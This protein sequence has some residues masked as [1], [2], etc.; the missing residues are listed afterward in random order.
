MSSGFARGALAALLL[1]GLVALRLPA[2]QGYRIG[3]GDTLKVL[4]LGQAELSGEFTVQPTGSLEFPFVGTLP[5]EGLTTQE[6][7]TALEAR[8]ADGFLKKPQVAVSVSESQKRRVFVAG[9]VKRPGPY[10]LRGDA[11]LLKLLSSVGELS[12]E[13]GHEVLV[14]RPPLETPGGAAAPAD[15]PLGARLP[16]EVPGAQ[17][18]RASLRELLAGQPTADLQLE[19]GDTVF[20]PKAAQVY[21][22]GHAV[23]P[24]AFKYD[25]GLTVHRLLA[26]AGGVNERG[27]SKLRLARIVDGKRRELRA[28]PTDLVQ[29]E[30]TLIVKERFF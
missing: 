7:Q 6:L 27:S 4:V 16:G 22:I 12:P 30:D 28:A 13:V 15:K 24:G 10:S 9:E 26:L 11:S 25:E 17:V 5:A 14:L 8:L 1:A 18:L 21:V 23:R 2:Q 20:F 3:V 19:P 29:P